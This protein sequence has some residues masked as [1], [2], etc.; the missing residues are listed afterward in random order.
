MKKWLGR[1]ATILLVCLILL[2]VF[3]TVTSLVAGGT[4]KVFGY[5]LMTVLSGS[6]EPGIKI[7]SVIAVK[8]VTDPEGYEEGDVVTYRAADDPNTFITHRVQQVLQ[9]GSGLAYVTKGDNND[10]ID[11][12]PV[13]ADQV[14]GEY[15]NITI[16]YLGY[17]LNVA[18]SK[19][20]I[21]L[22]LIVPGV[23]LLITQLV[24]VWRI[25][26]EPDDKPTATAKET[27]ELS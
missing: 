6:M 22:M 2:T 10:T 20:G 24:S 7:G 23:Y 26:S 11:I 13:S 21:V 16:P 8:S 19:L 9:E 4:P 5:E 15:A 25:M 3:F 14:V 1:L 17:V 12:A 18:K 27:K